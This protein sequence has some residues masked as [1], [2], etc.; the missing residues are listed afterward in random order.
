[1][2]SFEP[3]SPPNQ[4]TISRPYCHARDGGIPWHAAHAPSCHVGTFACSKIKPDPDRGGILE[5][6]TD[7]WRTSSLLV[8]LREGLSRRVSGRVRFER[9]LE[10]RFATEL[11]G[12]QP[13]AF[14]K[15]IIPS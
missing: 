13:A 14:L 11:T 2:S 4:S 8:A 10:W 1:M 15:E 7:W 12:V 5:F 9:C 3:Y 6:G